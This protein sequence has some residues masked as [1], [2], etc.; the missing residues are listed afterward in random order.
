LYNI[1]PSLLD[2]HIV[3][4]EAYGPVS[5]NGNQ[6]SVKTVRSNPANPGE[7]TGSATYLSFLS[8]ILHA[9]GKGKGIH[10]C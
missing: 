9:S 10:L 7:V 8:S 5:A 6:F 3:E 1:G 4:I 2:W